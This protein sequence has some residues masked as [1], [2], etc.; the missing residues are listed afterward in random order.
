MTN[1]AYENAPT[2]RGNEEMTP[3]DAARR[4]DGAVVDEVGYS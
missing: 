2:E 3:S 1:G 4:V